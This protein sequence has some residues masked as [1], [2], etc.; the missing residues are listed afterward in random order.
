MK[1]KDSSNYI[2]NFYVAACLLY[3]DYCVQLPDGKLLDDGNGLYQEDG[4]H[5]ILTPARLLLGEYALSAT[6]RCINWWLVSMLL[7][8]IIIAIAS[9]LYI[10]RKR[11][12]YN[13]N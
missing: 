1:L 3:V 10:S 11:N 6:C 4:L 13:P 2:E 5:F 9:A 8:L 12:C 7:L